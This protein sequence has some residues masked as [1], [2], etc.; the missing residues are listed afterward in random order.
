MY[1]GGNLV[2]GKQDFESVKERFLAMGFDRVYPLGTMPETPIEDLRKDL[3]ITE[4]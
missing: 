3:G 1:V 4:D 2:C